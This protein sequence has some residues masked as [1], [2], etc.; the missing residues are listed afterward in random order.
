MIGSGAGESEM[1]CAPPHDIPN[2]PVADHQPRGGG[3][4]WCQDL[5]RRAQVMLA[6]HE[7]NRARHAQGKTPVTDIWLWGQ[8]KPTKLEP[9]ASR[10]G[11][12]GV[13]ITGVDILRG[14]AVCMGMELIE[15]DG[16][17]GYLDTNYVGKGQ[18]GVRALDDFDLVVVHVEAPDEAGH[19]GDAKAKVE[20][21]EQVDRHVV[22][23]M[24]EAIRKL[25]EWKIM[26]APD[27]PTPSRPRL[28]HRFPPPFCFAGHNVASVE[29]RPFTERHADHGPMID[30][31]HKL[32]ELF[33]ES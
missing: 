2:E 28:I 23:P 17:T 9:F 8:G 16:A 20:A 27:H 22:G 33:F 19:L 1:I 29:G 32:I 14:L 31:G 4:A 6:D 13:V 21:I 7:V 10:F 15:V 12:R 5:M 3:A 18:A 30:P 11:C 25:D 24:L 26:V